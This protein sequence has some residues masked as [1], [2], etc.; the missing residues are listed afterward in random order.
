MNILLILQEIIRSAS[1]FIGLSIGI[2]GNHCHLMI[3]QKRTGGQMMKA[4]N[5]FLSHNW[6]AI[7]GVLMYGLGCFI[8]HYSERRSVNKDD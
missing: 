5:D 6:V 1:C 8:G 7:Y 2:T 3:V 4:I